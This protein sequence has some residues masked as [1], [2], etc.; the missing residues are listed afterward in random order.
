M[1]GAEVLEAMEKINALQNDSV[2]N[3]G[4]TFLEVGQK[5]QKR[6][7][8]KLRY[9]RATAFVVAISVVIQVSITSKLRT[10]IIHKR[11]EN[12][13]GPFSFCAINI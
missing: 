7:L 1:Q 5:Q 8:E 2:A 4:K 13:T 12:Q 6:K 11:K 9:A 10:V 3:R